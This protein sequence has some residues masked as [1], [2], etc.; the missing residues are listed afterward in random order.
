MYAQAAKSVGEALAA[1]NIP[2]VYGGGRRGLMGNSPHSSLGI[3]PDVAQEPYRSQHWIRE[4]TSTVSFRKHWSN[5]Q[6]KIHRH[7]HQKL[8]LLPVQYQAM[9][10]GVKRD[11]ERISWKM[12][13]M[14]D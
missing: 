9:Y 14:G 5:G 3:I 7:P 13:W 12:M 1:E 2:L 10:Y 11:K 8:D 4:V 6:V